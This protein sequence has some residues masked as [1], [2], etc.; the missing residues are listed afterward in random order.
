LILT[1]SETPCLLVASRWSGGRRDA[2]QL[3]GVAA[4]ELLSPGTVLDEERALAQP[5]EMERILTRLQQLLEA[6]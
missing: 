1:S 4:V 3:P 5:E 6:A 2:W